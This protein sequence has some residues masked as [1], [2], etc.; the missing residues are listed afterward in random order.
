M[1]NNW[2]CNESFLRVHCLAHETRFRMAGCA[3]ELDRFETVGKIKSESKWLI[4]QVIE[5]QHQKPGRIDINEFSVYFCFTI[6]CI[7]KQLI[8]NV[9][10]TFA[11]QF[12]IYRTLSNLQFVFTTMMYTLSHLHLTSTSTRTLGPIRPPWRWWISSD[13]KEYLKLKYTE[14]L[15]IEQAG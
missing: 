8:R 11:I 1:Q 2:Y 13:C 12:M 15:S 9:L 4:R 6:G 7:Y 14:F 5:V 3:A 10:P